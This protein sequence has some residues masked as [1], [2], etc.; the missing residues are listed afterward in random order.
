MCAITALAPVA[1]SAEEDAESALAR[2]LLPRGAVERMLQ[3]AVL[4][5]A[6]LAVRQDWILRRFPGTIVAAR[7]EVARA[8]A[9][10]TAQAPQAAAAPGWSKAAP[11]SRAQSWQECL[12]AAE[13][14]LAR[15]PQYGVVQGEMTYLLARIVNDKGAPAPV[16]GKAFQALLPRVRHCAW[17]LG[18][19]RNYLNG[20]DLPASEKY[21][22]ARQGEEASGPYPYARQYLWTFL[23]PYAKAAKTEDA[24]QEIE[25]F[26]KRYGADSAESVA[27][28]QLLL[29]RRSRA[30]DASAGEALRRLQQVQLEHTAAVRQLRAECDAAMAAGTCDGAVRRAQAFRKYPKYS[31]DSPWWTAFLNE[32]ASRGSAESQ[33]RA[34]RLALE[35][36]PHGQTGETVFQLLCQRP[37]AVV[38]EMADLTLR[39]FKDQAHDRLRDRHRATQIVRLFKTS[40][41]KPDLLLKAMRTAA[42]VAKALEM[43]DLEGELLANLAEQSWDHDQPTAIDALRRAAGLC[44]GSYDSARAGWLLDFLTGK[45]P[46]V[47]DPLPRSPSFL[48]DDNLPAVSLPPAPAPAA[49]VAVDGD[50]YRLCKLD[51]KENLVGR[52][53]AAVSSGAASAE[54]STDGKPDTY[55]KPDALPAV[56]IV[57]LKRPTTVAKISLRTVEQAGLVVSLLNSTGKTLGRYERSWNFWEQFRTVQHWSPDT[58]VLELLPVP[59]VSFVKVELLDA[60]GSFGGIREL[61]VYSPAYPA[62]ASHEL[63]AA[64]IPEGAAALA[65]QWQADQPGRETVYRGNL[66]SVRGFPVM[67]WSTPWRKQSGPVVLQQLGGN[68]A[69]EFFGRN[70]TLLAERE[71]KAVWTIDGGKPSVIEHP[72]KE[73]TEHRLAD[74]LGEGRHLLLLK[75]EALPARNDRWGADTLSFAG[76]KVQGLSRVAVAIRFGQPGG[77]WT[78]WTAVGDPAGTTVAVFGPIAGK[79]PAAYQV[80]LFFDSR[81]VM[82]ADTA[83]VRGVRVTAAKAGGSGTPGPLGVKGDSPVF[84]GART[85]TFPALSEELSEVAR[86]VSERKVVVAYP[87]T[88]TTAEYAAA[89][90]IAERAR[91]YLVSDDIGLN[92]YPG[93]VLAVGRP[94]VHRYSRQL[95][96][97]CMAWNDPDFLNNER[98]VVGMHRD[99]EGKPAWL[100]VT[101]ETVEAVERAADRLL[102]VVV[103]AAPAAEPFRMFASD[104]LEMVYPWQLHADDP[105]PDRLEMRLGVNDRRSVQFGISAAR[106]LKELEITC[107]PLRS[108]DGE[109]LPAPR[110]R[111]VGCYEWIPF[112]GDLRLPNLFLDKPLLPMPANTATGV[113]LTV[114]SS[115]KTRPGTYTGTLSVAAHGCRRE[116]TLR[117]TVEPVVL[118][119]LAR[120]KTYSFAGVPYW[121]HPWT[122]LYERALRELARNEAEHGVSVV[123][124]NFLMKARYT[125]TAR[126]RSRTD[127]QPATAAIETLRDP[128]AEPPV[129]L[130]FIDLDRQLEIFEEEY[131]RLGKPLPEFL[132]HAPDLQPINRDLFGEPGHFP[133]T[134][135]R[136]FS[137]QFVAH[138]KK[139]GRAGRFYLKISD[140][141][142][143][144]AQWA[145][146]ARPF[147]EEGVR[148]M[149]C[150]AAHYPNIATAAG[151]MD[152][153]CPNYQHEVWRPFFAERRKAGDALWWYCCG[154][155]PTRLTGKPADNLP[156]YWLTAKWR[157]D[158]AM[159]YAAMHAN[160]HSSMPVPFRYEHG[161]D[162]RIVYLADGS[163]LDTTRRE[164]E[165]DGISD[166][167]LIEHVRDRIGGLR[168]RQQEAAAQQ[169]ETELAAIIESV[170]PYRYGYPV[171]PAAWHKA[172]SALYDIALRL[173]RGP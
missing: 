61:E 106:D 59:D 134:A 87:K 9:L 94:M 102:Q 27:A 112:F 24:A 37:L 63:P 78:P 31:V 16:K 122:P 100:F 145:A 110:V 18:L 168:K 97:T 149:T 89:R 53:A 25:R 69:I 115:P 91:V 136:V 135:V 154:V 39:W 157:F 108:A 114:L 137:R 79:R 130:D 119:D 164:L 165:R 43:P 17:I 62:Q 80:G 152:P 23:E 88:G 160:P 12:D 158:G 170:V 131:R 82:A 75:N 20:L 52:Q 55:W 113:W 133:P 67:R 54:L 166:C 111:P 13:A 105:A 169:A 6:Q 65:V 171:E 146:W 155:P 163:V 33:T 103:P 76:L 38:P 140:E 85:G 83:S 159:N 72:V 162:H 142:G 51:P 74:N 132:C 29:E 70:A 48:N 148:T 8:Q 172:R 15:Y 45:L 57:P 96:A 35:C 2:S 49:E 84:V 121:F 118:P 129:V 28:E 144:I 143:D 98:G 30:G 116:V 26:R 19:T 109:Q 34:F 7:I 161:M 73:R 77:E 156:F 56:C 139:T 66:E 93:L 126:I 99:M 92:L 151:V 36:L 11:Q 104:V 173:D 1:G 147:R 58:L 150:H 167:K 120:P 10:L 32:V 68:L 117:V 46:L 101:G 64:P 71:G 21:R 86:L 123:Q 5:P 124:P 22:L 44:P 40:D 42:E 50:E 14:V 138:L 90:R 141:P 153:W 4:P 95:V 128:K 127:T 47:Q 41:V 81:A 125:A 3:Q 107:S 60:L